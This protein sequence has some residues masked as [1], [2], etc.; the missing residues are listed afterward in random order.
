MTKAKLMAILNT[1]PDSYYDISRAAT[2]EKAIGLALKLEKEG[3]DILDIGGE[4]TRPGATPV[5]EEEELKRV[6]PVIKE[7]K[8]LLSIPISIDTRRPSVAEAAISAGA[9]MLNDVTG[10]SHPDMIRLARD[11][12]YDICVMHMHGTPETMQKDV[13]K[14]LGGIVPYLMKWFEEKH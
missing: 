9:T 12:N 6:I 5:S 10:F 14:Y 7:L 2:A 1:T 11:T 4:S 8:G 3:A 13:P